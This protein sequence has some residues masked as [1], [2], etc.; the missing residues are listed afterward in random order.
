METSGLNKHPH[1]SMR[2]PVEAIPEVGASLALGLRDGMRPRLAL[3][4][5]L[6]GVV[7]FGVWLI[8]LIVW[9]SEIWALTDIAVKWVMN[10]LLTLVWPDLAGSGQKAAAAAAAAASNAAPLSGKAAG[11]ISTPLG[12]VVKLLVIAGSFLLLVMLSMRLY[13]ELFL[14]SRVQGQCLKHYPSLSPGGKAGFGVDVFSAL[15]LLSVLCAGLLLLIIPVIGGI[16][17]FLLASYLNVRSLMNDALEDLAT[18][19]ERRTIV[20]TMRAPMLLLGVVVAGLLL[21]PLAGLFIPAVLGASVCHLC[22]RALIRLRSTA[23]V[24]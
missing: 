10:G 13:L 5:I 3:M 23:P 14:M 4:S 15:K 12:S 7:A 24:V 17:F 21:I 2:R 6:A 20:K 9:R 11:W 16:L 1:L 8:V 18:A 22:M 19:E